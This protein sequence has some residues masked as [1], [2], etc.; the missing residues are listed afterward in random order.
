MKTATWLN[1]H[2][3]GLNA[4]KPK[5]LISGIGQLQTAY[6]LQNRIRLERP[7]LVI[8]AGIGGRPCKRKISGM[9]TRSAPKK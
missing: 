8:Q 1:N 5:L 9:F 2:S 7:D 4:L 3:L 6:A